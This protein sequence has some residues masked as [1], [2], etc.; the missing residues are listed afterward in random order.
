[1]NLPSGDLVEINHNFRRHLAVFVSGVVV[2]LR[3]HM[4]RVGHVTRV[5]SRQRA[6]PILCDDIGMVCVYV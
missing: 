3:R 2:G 1:M 6:A 5:E 4:T